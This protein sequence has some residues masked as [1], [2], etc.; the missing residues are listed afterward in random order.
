LTIPEAAEI[1]GVSRNTFYTWVRKKEIK[2]Y[3]TPGRT[4]FIRPSDL[5]AF[6]QQAGLFVPEDL[7]A[8]AKEDQERHPTEPVQDSRP[9]VLVVDDDSGARQVLVHGLRSQ[10]RVCEARTGYEAL[11]QLTCDPAIRVVVLDM[12]M[13]GQH[14]LQTLQ[15]VRTLRPDVRVII[16]T[17]FVGDVPDEV[18]QDKAVAATLQ[19]PVSMDELRT[20]VEQ[21]WQEY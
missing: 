4:N 10:Y 3:Q 7:Q 20:I 17:G 2:A 9:A 11:H 8:M 14:G 15:E 18:V 6:M 5:V 13:P 21:A 16:V 19:K 1:C 12:R